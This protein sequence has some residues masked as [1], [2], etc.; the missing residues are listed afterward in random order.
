MEPAYRN[1]EFN[2]CWKLHHHFSKPKR[3]DVVVI[4]FAGQRV[5][6]LKRVVALENEEVEFRT[7]QLFIDGKELKEPYIHY[8]YNWSLLAR[9]VEPDSVYVV[10]DNRGGPIDNH[11]FGQV[12]LKRILGSPL[13]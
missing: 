6:L 13:W 1:G 11:S 4:R 10:G 5:M 7:G 9:R 2:F 12:T 3:G 8:P